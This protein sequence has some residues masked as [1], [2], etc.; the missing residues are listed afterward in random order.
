MIKNGKN[1]AK[2]MS[3]E[4]RWRRYEQAKQDLFYRM[5]DMTPEQVADAHAAI[6]EKYRV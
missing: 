3:M 6:R 1:R 5:K 2:R 4:E